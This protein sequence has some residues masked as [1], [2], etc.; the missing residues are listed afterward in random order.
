MPPGPG[1]QIVP[2]LHIVIVNWNA[3]VQLRACLDS[4]RAAL[5]D[6]FR[7]ARV[8]VVDNASSD[9]SL[10]TLADLDLPLGIIR[11]TANRGFG[12]ACNQGA[13]DAVSDYL[14]FLNP[15]TRLTPDAL[16]APIRFLEQPE[17]RQVAVASIQLVDD[18]GVV[19]RTC[20]RFPTPAMFTTNMLG[21][22]RLW[23]DVFPSH[24]MSTWDHGDT[25]SVPHVIGAFY[26]V[27]RSVFE[28]VEGFDER[29]FVYLEDLDLSRR[30]HQAGWDIR[31]L[32]DVRA[33]HRGGGTSE[34]VKAARL[35]YALHSRMRYGF[36][37]FGPVPAAMLA[38][39]TLL[40]E[41]LVRSAHAL[42][43]RRPQDVA[44]VYAAFRLL[45]R[46]VLRRAHPAAS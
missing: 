12:A 14:L 13:R 22:D 39:G 16:A 2:S 29:Y 8:T 1:L 6:R 44:E 40:V 5:D 28:S 38:G 33:Y 4:M 19:S 37:H 34:Q 25:R 41:P 9:G 24:F 26:L 46:A 23:P 45:W 10:E 11:N 20:T 36:K 21:L 32:A 42:A 27:R 31:Y 15:D 43:R 17:H 7:L 35:A 3:G 18:A 30:I